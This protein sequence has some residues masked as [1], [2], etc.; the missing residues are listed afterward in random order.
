MG[1]MITSG[2][3]D[4]TCLPTGVGFS[5]TAYTQLALLLCVNVNFLMPKKGRGQGRGS[6]S[7]F[8]CRGMLDGKHGACSVEDII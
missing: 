5:I 1:A 6:L 3:K 4:Y 7:L 8:S 2:S